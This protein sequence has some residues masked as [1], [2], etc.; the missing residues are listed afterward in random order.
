M[1]VIYIQMSGSKKKQPMNMTTDIHHQQPFGC[2]T[3]EDGVFSMY[4]YITVHSK[5]YNFFSAENFLQ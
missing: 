3:L 2:Y 1:K 4:F 5:A